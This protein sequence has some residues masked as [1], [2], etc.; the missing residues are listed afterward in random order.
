MSLVV[1]LVRGA[2]FEERTRR[3]YDAYA[4][5]AR[6]FFL[7]H[8][9][10]DGSRWAGEPARTARLRAGRIVAGPGREDGII[11]VPGGLV[12]HWVGAVFIP[13][14]TLDAALRLSQTYAEYPAIYESVIASR[15]F[16]REGDRFRVLLRLEERAGMV[17]AVLDVWS[18]IRYVRVNGAR[19][20]SLS[21]ATE[22]REVADAA[23]S[24][25]RLLPAGEDR[26]YLWRANA[27]TKYVERDGGVYVELETLG[28]SRGF[29]P[30]LGWIIEPIARRIGRKSVEGSLREFRE[31]LPGTAAAPGQDR[32]RQP[33]LRRRLGHRSIG[34]ERVLP[35]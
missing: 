31:A 17:T 30:L 19:A 6:Q 35:S 16:G 9:P 8:I 29:P 18:A 28:L 10:T 12:H 5:Q 22:I 13:N 1:T 7:E 27:F 33:S 2:E 24:N 4:E 11:G 15:F 26:G 14:V 20:Y 23:Q 32:S 3:A 21:D 25:E 34:V